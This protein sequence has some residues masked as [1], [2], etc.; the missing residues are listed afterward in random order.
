MSKLKMLSL[1]WLVALALAACSIPDVGDIKLAQCMDQCTADFTECSEHAGGCREGCPVGCS[2]TLM[3]KEECDNDNE[4]ELCLVDEVF[5][6]AETCIE[7][8]EA[9][10]ELVLICD[11]ECVRDLQRALK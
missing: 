7:E 9:C 4:P 6:C 1:A 11:T 10:F 8:R 3:C 2:E 5:E